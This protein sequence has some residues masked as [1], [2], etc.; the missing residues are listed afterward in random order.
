MFALQTSPHHRPEERAEA[1]L[2][3][4]G[5]ERDGA[6]AALP[7]DDGED[8][9][10]LVPQ[11]GRARL[12]VHQGLHDGDGRLGRRRHQDAA[13][14]PPARHRPGR[15]HEAHRHVDNNIPGVQPN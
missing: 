15:L 12:Q 10:G 8:D 13:V 14:P 5:D 9:G 2:P 7:Q 6:A 4:R 11:A 1:G 3:E